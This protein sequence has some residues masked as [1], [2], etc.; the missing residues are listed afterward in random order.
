MWYA[1]II[2]I[3]WIIVSRIANSEMDTIVHVPKRSWAYKKFF[4]KFISIFT[5]N[6]SDFMN[7]WYLANNWKPDPKWNCCG[8]NIKK[9]YKDRALSIFIKPESC[10]PELLRN[11]PEI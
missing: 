7:K 4:I 9:M 8:I 1:I 10:S 5:N 3:F 6:T 2:T 11:N